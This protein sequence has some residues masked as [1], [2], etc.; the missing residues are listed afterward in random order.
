VSRQPADSII[1]Y[2]TSAGQTASDGQG[3]NGLFTS[4]LLPN[5]LT[6]GLDVA[7]VF[8]RTGADVAALSQREQVPAFYS[9]F[10]GTAYL[11]GAPGGVDPAQVYI[12]GQA[13]P[14][15]LPP[16]ESDQAPGGHPRKERPGDDASRLWTAGASLGSSFAA[17]WLM[18]T[19]RG[20][21]APF[22]NSFFE[23]GM[24]FGLVN[25]DEKVDSYFSMSPFAHYVY[26]RP[27]NDILGAYAGAGAGL[28][29]ISYKFDDL[30]T[31][32]KSY[33]IASLTMGVMLFDR[34]NVSYSLRTNFSGTNN[35]LSAGYMYRFK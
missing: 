18:A 23:L 1:V 7:E 27:L 11:A 14:L 31:F 26:Y 35:K 3:R 15:P 28:W 13:R 10:F 17:P 2:A 4:Q 32:T 29:I 5:L 22:R 12:P 19:L 16:P 24:D 33:F 30:E 21:I 34:I 20:T 8:R 6:P 9:Q 25:P